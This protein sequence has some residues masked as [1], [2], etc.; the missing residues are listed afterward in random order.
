[1]LPAIGRVLEHPDLG[2]VAPHLIDGIGEA[3]RPV[4]DVGIEQL[5]VDG[6]EPVAAIE[7]PH[8]PADGP[9][10]S[11]GGNGRNEDGTRL[12]SATFPPTTRNSS[13]RPEH[14]RDRQRLYPGPR[15]RA[16][17][18]VGTLGAARPRRRPEQKAATRE[19][20]QPAGVT[21]SKTRLVELA[22][23]RHPR[24]DA[25]FSCA[26]DLPS[27]VADVGPLDGPTIPSSIL[28]GAL[29]LGQRKQRQLVCTVKVNIGIG[30]N[31]FSH[32]WLGRGRLYPPV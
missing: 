3:T 22:P 4:V 1:M 24:G 16:H 30:D 28:V 27:C 2:R 12:G 20:P 15:R 14:G 9:L 25:P 23:R 7:A 10:R 32:R 17:R 11:T 21:T 8:P 29:G 18:L 5:T 26:H 6:P 19:Q 31:Y 13:A